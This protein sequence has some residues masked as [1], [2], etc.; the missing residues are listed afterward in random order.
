MGGTSLLSVWVSDGG[1][2]WKE[3]PFLKYLVKFNR[4]H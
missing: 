2:F 4:W 1:V 3:D